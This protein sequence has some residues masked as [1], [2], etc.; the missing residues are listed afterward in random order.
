MWL[1][2][3]WKLKI[4]VN[5]TDL[6]H[7]VMF[8]HSFDFIEN[9]AG[10]LRSSWT[11]VVWWSLLIK[12]AKMP[13]G[14]TGIPSSE[15]QHMLFTSYSLASS[16]FQSKPFIPAYT[17]RWGHSIWPVSRV[18]KDAVTS[19]EWPHAILFVFAVQRSPSCLTKHAR[20]CLKIPTIT[21]VKIMFTTTQV[22]VRFII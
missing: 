18:L 17:E 1:R 13:G 14:E 15:T 3:Q 8:H 22:S 20:R 7:N 12:L 5:Q 21:L 19:D 11:C 10:W 9:S 2:P 16:L 6:F 4:M